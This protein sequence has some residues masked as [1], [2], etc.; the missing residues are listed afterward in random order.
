MSQLKVF[1][2]VSATIKNEKKISHNL[3]D[4]NIL[5]LLLLFF[6]R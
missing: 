4:L 2:L 3:M 6:D 5:L 1:E